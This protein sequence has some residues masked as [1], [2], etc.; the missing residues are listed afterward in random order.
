MAYPIADNSPLRSGLS[1]RV[2]LA[3][4]RAARS[5]LQPS[6]ASTL[7][8]RWP[9]DIIT[10]SPIPH[11]V[12]GCLV[13]HASGW[14]IVGIGINA[15]NTPPTHDPA[16]KPLRTPAISLSEIDNHPVNLHLLEQSIIRELLDL[17]PIPGLTAGLADLLER[18]LHRPTDVVTVEQPGGMHEQALCLG[19]VKEG[20]D[21]GAMRIRTVDGQERLI[22]SGEFR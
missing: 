8:I 19:V 16:G 15:N 13:E 11:K 18:S 10:Q 6:S 22:H 14:A 3:A 1:L 2:G 21:L 20:P 17:I 4:L 9:N 7:A 5:T 12:G